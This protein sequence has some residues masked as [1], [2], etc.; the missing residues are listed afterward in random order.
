MGIRWLKKSNRYIHQIPSDAYRNPQTLP[1]GAVLV[2]GSA[3]SGCQ[4]AE[5][6]HEAGR[7][8]YLSTG[9]AGR[10]P[11]RYR[12]LDGFDWLTRVGFF[13]RTPAMLNS[14]KDR[15]FH[16]SPFIGKGGRA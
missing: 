9:S 2:V 8:V 15:F 10:I 13:D 16:P 14:S 3:Q 7:K 4:I 5:E 12:G 6:L 11:R 1:P